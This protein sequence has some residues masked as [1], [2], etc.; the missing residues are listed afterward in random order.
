[1]IT[2]RPNNTG[3]LFALFAIIGACTLPLLPVGLELAVEVTRNADASSALL[4][5][6]GN[7]FGVISLA[8]EDAL[9][10][11]EDASPPKSMK[12][13]LIFQGVVVLVACVV[14]FGIRGN[15]AR[16]ERDERA[17]AGMDTQG[18]GGQVPVG[19]VDSG[20]AS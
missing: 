16:R 2:A 6:A 17:Q 9:R 14:A 11:G 10:L 19:E 1:V 18:G 12:H 3:A 15:Q 20:R 4:F 8:I 5:F 13:A 7:A